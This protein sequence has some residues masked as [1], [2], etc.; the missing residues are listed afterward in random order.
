MGEA[1]GGSSPFELHLT[2][3]AW[4]PCVADIRGRVRDSVAPRDDP[5]VGERGE[6]QQTHSNPEK[7]STSH[8]YERSLITKERRAY[9]KEKE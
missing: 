5:R 6:A 9:V 8:G 1:A 3:Q 2:M 7:Y 4:N